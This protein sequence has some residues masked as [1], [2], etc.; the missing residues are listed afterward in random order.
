MAS[1]YDTI[2]QYQERAIKG[3]QSYASTNELSPF[4]LVAY[5]DDEEKLLN[6]LQDTCELL[7]IMQ[8]DRAWQ[9][10]ENV[11]FYNGIQH[12]A[13]NEFSDGIARDIRGQYL[14][15]GDIFV[16]NHARD[17]VNQK[18]SMLTRFK[19][20]INVLPWNST[21]HDRLGAKFS[22]RAIDTIF[23]D[24]E[25]GQVARDV[26][27]HAATC[28]EGYARIKWD[29]GIGELTQEQ[30]QVNMAAREIGLVDPKEIMTPYESPDG[31]MVYFDMQQRLGDVRVEFLYPWMVLKE[32]AYSWRDVNYLFVLHVKHLEQVRMEN[33]SVDIDGSMGRTDGR[34]KGLFTSFLGEGD[35]VV[36]VEFYHKPTQFLDSGFYAKFC[37]GTLLETS[38]LPFKKLP[39]ARFTD[40][41]DLITP[42]GR[43]FLTDIR[44]PLILHNKLLNLMYRNV[45]IAGHPKLLVQRGTVNLTSM[46]AGPLIV[47]YDG[48][49]RPEIMTFNAIGGEVFSL[50]QTFMNQIQQVAG[51]FGL[52]RGDT[53]PNARAAEILS[54][55]Q[56]QEEQ[57]NGPLTD[58]WIA[59]I[60][61]LAKLT[62]D[63]AAENY[64]SDDNRALRIFGKN[65]GYKLRRLL[66]VD[67]L[68]GPSSVI[69]ERTTSLD[70]TRQGKINK[71]VQLQ[72][73]PMGDGAP[74]VFKREQII[75]MLDLADTETFFDLYTAAV[76][77]AQSENEDMYEGFPVEAPQPYQNLPVHWN[78]H[79]LF[80]QS[81]EFSDTT[82]VP[83][84]VRQLFAEH[85]LATEYLMYEKAKR[86]FAFA[87]ELMTLPHFP[88]LLEIGPQSAIPETQATVAQLL[89]LHQQPPLPATPMGIPS[90]AVAPTEEP[91]V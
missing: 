76:D 42:H 21:Y 18:V 70:D 29:K 87:Q 11:N 33:P 77:S 17:F 55:Y 16:M 89:L 51:V 9:M 84:A 58:K 23:Y 85:L 53:V 75:R 26:A 57:R 64:K 59:W 65:N 54:I 46:A 66:E 71:I 15:D 27:F 13:E 49:V 48:Q 20:A 63:C 37:S 7:Q 22:K 31:S 28:G 38:P 1:A 47:E 79:F 10:I 2:L 88:C 6:W 25:I 74:G 62:L 5:S 68:K 8:R 35:Y 32:P 43:S 90:K 73:L 61:K 24:N 41:D 50:A 45:A 60:E 44:P 19:P 81:K 3:G 82:S 30:A 39:I 52:S 56:E 91:P 36:E 69:V 34:Y 4:P 67:G 86:S 14:Q 80:M 78:E 72:Q 40:Y 83:Q 12:L